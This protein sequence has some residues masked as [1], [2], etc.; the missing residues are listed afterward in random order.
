MKGHGLWPQELQS[1]GKE[2]Q[3]EMGCERGHWG[4]EDSFLA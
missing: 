2:G 4:S 3:A 1:S